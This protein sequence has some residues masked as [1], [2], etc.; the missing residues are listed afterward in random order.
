MALLTT[1][2]DVVVDLIN[3]EVGGSGVTVE[4]VYLPLYDRK[5]EPGLK[6]FV[7][8]LSQS[9]NE[10]NRS[11]DLVSY[12]IRVAIYNEVDPQDVD[13]VDLMVGFT[14]SLMSVLRANHHL[15]IGTDATA[16]LILPVE[17][18]PAYDPVQLDSHQTFVSVIALEYRVL[19]EVEI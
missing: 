8:G 3:D 2:A 10:G 15:Q 11:A 9:V 19:L 6:I 13:E 16:E 4:R 14:E 17:N 1:I 18:D 5:D 7:V 12:Q